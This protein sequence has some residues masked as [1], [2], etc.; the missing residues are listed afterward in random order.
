MYENKYDFTNALVQFERS[1][2]LRKRCLTL[3]HPLIEE[4][5]ST[6]GFVYN[7]EGNNV[8]AL[9]YLNEAVD[10]QL[11]TESIYLASTCISIG[12][13]HHSKQDHKNV[14]LYY[15]KALKYAANDN[16]ELG[17]LYYQ[18]GLIYDGEKDFDMALENYQNTLK[19]P[20]NI[21]SIIVDIYNR[22]GQI[23]HTKR[24]YSEVLCNYKKALSFCIEQKSDATLIYYH[25]AW[26]YDNKLEHKKALRFYK[27]ALNENK[28]QESPSSDL[29]S[30]VYNNMAGIYARSD[31]FKS[32]YD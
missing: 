2:D 29:F 11:K 14:L 30:R 31:E 5:L 3:D 4:T 26:V 10:L 28:T 19:F 24:D 18:I 6:M 20:S 15:Q 25:M 9:V 21:D 16:P 32:Q 1:L 7:K 22:M 12:S 13:I 23:Y 27:K 8:K 17:P